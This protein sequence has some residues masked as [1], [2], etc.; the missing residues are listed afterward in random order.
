MPLASQAVVTEPDIHVYGEYFPRPTTTFPVL[1]R[2]P[3]N[4]GTRAG[5]RCRKAQNPSQCCVAFHAFNVP[6]EI[7]GTTITSSARLVSRG[8]FFSGVFYPLAVASVSSSFFVCADS[9]GI[10]ARRASSE[11]R[12]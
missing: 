4:H 11:S 6:A 9:D 1:K 5:G 7:R 2:P 10:R 12:K 3:A 8:F